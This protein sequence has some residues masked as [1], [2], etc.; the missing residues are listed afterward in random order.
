LPNAGK[1]TLFKA[2]TKNKVD[3]AAYPFTTIKP[4]LGIVAVPDKRLEK[5][6]EII[7]PEKT[8]PTIIEFI[9]IA[10]LVKGAHLGQGLGNQFLAQIRTC[11]AILEVVRGFNKADVEHVEGDINPERDAEIIKLE[12]L[13]KDLETLEAILVRL[14]K[15]SKTK[16]KKIIGQIELFKRIKDW[17]SKERLIIELD[18]KSEERLEIKEYQFLTDKPIIYI[19]NTNQDKT[20]SLKAEHLTLN[21]KLEE[22][23]SD[24]SEEEQK[25]LGTN[26]MLDQ[27]IIACYN[28]LGLITFFTVAG[29][30][31]TRA[32]T[33]KKGSKAPE[34]GGCVHSD[35]QDKFIKAEV[36][37]WNKL[38][39][40]GNWHKARELGWLKTAGHD[41]LVEDGDVIEFK[42]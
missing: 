12:L 9:D 24:L 15:E 37:S 36:I 32:W 26:P 16:D 3:I 19:L 23:I 8:T 25:E 7:K 5:V 28:T 10:G 14:E 22:E 11:S 29:G 33:I 20:F 18:L 2:L 42:I 17:V 30:K 31:E 6:A 35:F 40:A 21:L 27:L 13:M 34:A 39:E 4:N 38:V 1:S 41:Y